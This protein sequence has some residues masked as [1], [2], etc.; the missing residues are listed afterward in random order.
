MHVF[1]QPLPVLED[2]DVD[3]LMKWAEEARGL[4]K[5]IYGSR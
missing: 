4:L 1:H 2:M 5:V 3:D